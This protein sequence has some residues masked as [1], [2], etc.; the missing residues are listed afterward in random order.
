MKQ[1]LNNGLQTDSPQNPQVRKLVAEIVRAVM[2][3]SDPYEA[4]SRSLVIDLNNLTI[5]GNQY[6]MDITQGVLLCSIG[7]AARLMAKAAVDLLEDKVVGGLVIESSVDDLTNLPALLQII[8]GDHPIPVVKSMAAGVAIQHVLRT[9][10]EAIPVLFLISG[11]GS[12]LMTMPYPGISLAD[13]KILNQVMLGH[14]LAIDEI[15][16][17]RK[18]ID[19]TKGGGLLR[20]LGKSPSLTLVLSDVLSGDLSM[21]ASGPTAADRSTFYVLSILSK[22]MSSRD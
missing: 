5:A 14:H 1:F 8:Q 22:S 3:A 15:N 9:K 20:W 19:A 11:G 7:K 6:Q 16:V 4:V 13:L 18:H 2:N 17:I 12:S 10:G 21:V